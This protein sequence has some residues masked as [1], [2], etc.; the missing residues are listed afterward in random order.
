MRTSNAL[1]N[2]ITTL[3][4]HFVSMLLGFISQAI[5]VKTL[6]TEYL[7]VNGLFTN[8][9]SMLGVVELGIGSAII[10][11]LYKPIAEDDK[12]TV[13]SL[14]KFYKKCYRI[15]ALIIFILGLLIIPFLNIIVGETTISNNQILLIYI[16]FITDI[17]FSYLLTYK[18]SI[19]Y[20][21]QK[22]YII[23]IIHI[24]YLFV[25]NI[26]QIIILLYSRNY[27][28]YLIFKI[29]MRLLENIIITIVANK[30]YTYITE[31]NCINIDKRIVSD[32]VKKVKGLVIHKI[33]VFFVAGTDN[34]IISSFLGVATVGLYSNYNLIISAIDTIINEIF[35]SFKSS[36]GNLLVTSNEEKTYEVYKR[37]KFLNFWFA[38]MSSI[39]IFVVMESFITV[40]IGKEYILPKF[41]LFAL[42][43]NNFIYVT[44]TCTS[45]FQE[46]AGIF[47]EDRYIPII[48]SIVNISFSI[49]FLKIFGL[50]GVFLGTACS[51][52]ITHIYTYPKF[53]YQGIFKKKYSQ[54]FKD[55][56]KYV[57]ISI[58]AGICT[59]IISQIIIVKNILLEVIINVF[60]VLIIPNIFIIIFFHKTAEFKYYVNILKNIWNKVYIK[61]KKGGKN[62]GTRISI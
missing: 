10:Y 51:H 22:N 17:V 50:A 31:K 27:I 48:E 23:D 42:T 14:M 1:R 38:M 5:F 11:N 12:E 33:G 8:I 60:I 58:L 19:L 59:Y 25:F 3:I 13:K 57:Y 45:N 32:I 9:I 18:R 29:F 24:I 54:Y 56:S 28:L 36:I 53:V 15:I 55:M 21:Y 7:G 46:A 41:V 37:L 52:L 2:M 20:A 6:G 39:G 43:T 35:A 30:K 47:Y 44:K 26:I 49:I 40:W 4:S 16:L 61:I 34:I 62:E